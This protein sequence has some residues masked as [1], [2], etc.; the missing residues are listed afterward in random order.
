[1]PASRSTSPSPWVFS[2]S[3]VG[4]RL[5]SNPSKPREIAAFF[6]PM[7]PDPAR[8]ATTALPP[9]PTGLDTSDAVGM[10]QAPSGAG[11]ATSVDPGPVVSAPAGFPSPCQAT[12][13][14]RRRAWR[15]WAPPKPSGHPSRR[16]GQ[17][18]STHQPLLGMA[19]SSAGPRS[20]NS[21]AVG[22]H[23]LGPRQPRGMILDCAPESESLRR[24]QAYGIRRREPTM[25]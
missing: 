3:S 7:G 1:V 12:N 17:L 8:R 24:E 9:F 23:S 2:E 6:L 10:G 16:P 5:Q 14:A 11:R 19:R 25:L 15:D 21:E 22:Q 4:F 13:P 20:G 18:G